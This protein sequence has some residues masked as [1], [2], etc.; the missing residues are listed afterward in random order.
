MKIYKKILIIRTDRLGDVILSTPVIENLRIAYP[1][2]H[3]A[4]MCRP[5][6]KEVLEGNPFLDETIV[7]DK[8]G[9]QKSFLSTVK[10]ALNLRKEKFDCVLILHPTNRVHIISFL[11]AIPVRIGWRSNGALL[12]TKKVPYQKHEGKKHESEYALDI[13]RALGV[14]ITSR[15]TFF[16]VPSQAKIKV[17]SLLNDYNVRRS[18][19]LIIVHPSASCVSKRWPINSFSLMIHQIQKNIS[20]HVAVIA[21]E[22]EKDICEK[23]ISE[24]NT[25]DFRGKLNIVET[26]ALIERGDLFI[27]NDSGPVH[28]A[29]SLGRP[30]ISIFG[31]N[32][33]GLSPRRWR[34][35]G[36]NS[37]YFHEKTD[38]PSCLAHNCQVGFKCLNNIDP[39]RVV[40][41][42]L[43]I[44]DELQELER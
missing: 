35:L 30:V 16:P 37:Y 13:V 10:F 22:S 9:K 11:A 29:A 5:Y 42:A 36:R 39:F 6:T 8:Y 43:E 27:S 7:Y 2:A 14:A 26:G 25:I 21:T 38:C 1:D 41:K 40:H 23:I 32:D 34:P 17:E 19:I 44:I 20:C 24:N 18:D 28:I 12:L 15:N 33:P 31:R 3:I 4:F